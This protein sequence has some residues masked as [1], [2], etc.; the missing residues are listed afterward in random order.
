FNDL[1]NFMVDADRLYHQLEEVKNIEND[2][3]Y[4]TRSQIS[5]IQDFWRSFEVKDKLHQE[6]F[7]K[8]W[9]LL[10]TIYQQFRATL[11][12]T[13]LAYS[14]MLYRQVVERLKNL[15]KPTQHFIFIGSNAFSLTDEKLIKHFIKEFGADIFWD[16]DAY[17]LEDPRQEAGMFF[18]DYRKDKVF[19]PTFPKE[20]K[21]NIRSNKAK[22]HI[23]STPL[24]VNQANLVG[25]LMEKIPLGESLEETVVI[26][27]DE[28]QLF[29]ILHALPKAIDK[30]NVTMGYPVRNSPAYGF[31]ESLLELQKFVSFKEGKTVFYHKPVRSILSS[32]SIRAI[33][34]EFVESELK[35]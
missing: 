6:K 24:K 10:R 26:L 22:I 1:D 23:Y 25:K 19:G 3:T 18:R 29:P 33:N 30:V 8:F 21:D 32:T 11:S 15:E 28:Q 16:V 9:K 12:S 7:L 4:L 13:G 17:Y 31:L 5:L 14:G 27:P 35:W 20:I 2:L 34:K